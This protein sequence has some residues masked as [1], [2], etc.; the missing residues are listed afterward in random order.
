MAR[1]VKPAQPHL[2]NSPACNSHWRR[3]LQACSVSQRH[4]YWSVS[5]NVTHT[6]ARHASSPCHEPSGF[7]SVDVFS[8]IKTKA[9]H[10]LHFLS[11]I[12]TNSCLY[13][14]SPSLI[15]SHPL[16]S[17]LSS[18]LIL[19]QSLI[20]SHHLSHHLSSSLILSH[21]LSPSFDLVY[22]TLHACMHI[23]NKRCVLRRQCWNTNQ[24]I[25]RSV[26]CR[27]TAC[28]VTW[29]FPLTKVLRLNR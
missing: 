13:Q 26:Y 16:S 23:Y 10:P 20:M 8:T 6:A 17:S 11:L 21:H 4:R 2:S 24:N 28:K 12:Y 25:K 14:L 27:Y 1:D 22:G 3:A 9:G 15:L 7:R 19:S 18:S 29:C 5:R